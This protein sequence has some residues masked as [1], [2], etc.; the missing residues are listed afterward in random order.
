MPKKTASKKMDVRPAVEVKREVNQSPAFFSVYA[1]DAQ[2]QTSPWDVR[3][4]FG[5]IAKPPTPADPVAN[6]NQLGQLRISLQLAK[7]LAFIMTQQ[8]QAYE[9]RF[10]VLPAPPEE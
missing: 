6:I 3:I 9:T 8:I 10:G 5:E 7:R 1:N 4:I 2:V